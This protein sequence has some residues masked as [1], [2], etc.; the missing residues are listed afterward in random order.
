MSL[1]ISQPLPAKH[2]DIFASHVIR[3]NGMFLQELSI[4]LELKINNKVFNISGSD[5]ANF[6]VKLL[7]YGFEASIDFWL[8]ADYDKLF[9]FFTK[10][11]LMDACFIIKSYYDPPD[12]LPEPVQIRGLVYERKLSETNLAWVKNQPTLF[13]HYYIKMADPAKVLWNQHYPSDLFVDKTMKDVIEAH[14]NEKITIKYSWDQMSVKYPILFLGLGRDGQIASFYDFI[15]WL[16]FFYNGVFDYESYTN[17]YKL[18]KQKADLGKPSY[19]NYQEVETWEVCFPEI[20]RNNVKLLNSYTENAK[21]KEIKQDQSLKGVYKD[22]LLRTPVSKAFADRSTLEQNRLKIR[23]P[24]VK[25][26]FKDFPT[27]TLKPGYLVR[28]EKGSW[29]KQIFLQG[30]TYRVFEVLL[31]GKA[32]TQIPTNIGNRDIEGY[33]TNIHALL[34]IKEETYVH[35]PPFKYPQYPVYAEGKIVSEAGEEKEETYQIYKD[36]DTSL[37]FYKVEMPLWN[38]QKVIVPFDPNLFSGHFYFPAFKNARVLLGFEFQDAWIED[39]LDWR[40]GS[41]L[42]EDTQGNHILLGLEA[43]S[44]TSI[45][46]VYKDKKPEFNIKRTLK[47]DTELIQFKEGTIILETKEEK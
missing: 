32:K 33:E 31:E 7:S 25:V 39:F 17:S 42:G 8:Q 13:R 40:A 4:N 19:I 27:L 47:K 43:E 30:K 18:L 35:L 44:K 26:I 45:N 28:F 36:K 10:P 6:S 5:I 37:E 20:I 38:K 1:V 34:E 22:I 15:I 11:D 46:H 23:E 2:L 12:P 41:R 14:K 24:Y 29:S 16:T 3:E 21:T 9:T